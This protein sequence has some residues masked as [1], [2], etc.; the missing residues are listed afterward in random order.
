VKG[1]QSQVV[2]SRPG[3]LSSVPYAKPTWL[4]PVFKSPYFKEICVWIVEDSAG[5]RIRG[6]GSEG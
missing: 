6:V 4:T 3:D 5:G 1:E 2:E